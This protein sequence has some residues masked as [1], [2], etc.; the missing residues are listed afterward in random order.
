MS[1]GIWRLS[2]LLFASAVVISVWAIFQSAYLG[3]AFLL[4]NGY[5]EDWAPGSAF[6]RRFPVPTRRGDLRIANV[7]GLYLTTILLVHEHRQ[8]GT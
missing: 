6:H 8:Q 4:A 3:P 1:R 2:R 5:A 7:F